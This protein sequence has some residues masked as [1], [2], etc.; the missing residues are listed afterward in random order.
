MRT[1]LP[2]FLLLGACG[3]REDDEDDD[4]SEDQFLEDALNEWLRAQYPEGSPPPQGAANEVPLSDAG[5][6]S[7]RTP[8]W[9]NQVLLS[10]VRTDGAPIDSF[11]M[12]FGAI[13]DGWCIPADD[14]DVDVQGDSATLSLTMPPELCANLSQICHDIRCYEFATTSQ[15]TFTAGNVAYLAAA[16]GQCDE[17]SCADLIDSCSLDDFCLTDD[18]CPEEEA[19]LYGLCV[20]AGALRFSLGW[21]AANTDFDLYVQ[22]PSGAVISYENRSADG[23]Q[24]DRDDTDGGPNS[25]ENIFFADPAPGDYAVWVDLYGGPGGAWTLT[26]VDAGGSPLLNEAG[27]LTGGSGESQ[28]FTVTVP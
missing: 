26:V 8:V 24:L 9:S 19:C 20:G 13:E 12:S 21:S 22:T 15:G 4:P 28:T 3:G 11:C 27:S 16:C 10:R 2:L 18:D 23:G 7:P 6:A 17:P 14:P 1:I 25:L 5:D